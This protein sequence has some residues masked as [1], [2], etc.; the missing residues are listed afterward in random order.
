MI[1]ILLDLVVVVGGLIGAVVMAIIIAIVFGP[2]ITRSNSY[3]PDRDEFERWMK[4]RG[5]K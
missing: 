1:N 4:K 3:N 2:D 5:M